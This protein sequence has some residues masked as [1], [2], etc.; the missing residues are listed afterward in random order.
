LNDDTYG[1][2]LFGMNASGKSSL[3]KA[4]G[5]NI[6]MA[7]AGMY[8]PAQYFEYSPYEHISPVYQVLIIYIVAG[9]ASQLK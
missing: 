5:L 2:L 1:L 7:Q 8:V 3:M 4:I 6:I 9:V